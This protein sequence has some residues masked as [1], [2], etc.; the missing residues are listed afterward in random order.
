MKR[1]II[2][3]SSF[4]LLL[5]VFYIGILSYYVIKMRKYSFALPPIKTVLVI[6]DSQTQADIN[7]SILVNVKNLSLAHD[8]YF[9]MF[10]R[11]KLYTDTNPQIDHVIIALSPHTLSPIKDDF[12]HNFGYVDET[13]KHYMP[14]FNIPDW[15]ILIKND[16]ADVLSS[17][18]TPINY[19]LHPSQDRIKEM[20]FYESADY[21][22]LEEDIKSGATR[23]VPDSCETNYGNAITVMYLHKI[24]D[25]CKGK[26]IKLIGI[27]T[28]VLHGE[29]YFDMKNYNY[30]ISHDFKDIEVWNYMDMAVPDSC[31]RDV[32]HLNKWGAETFSN[33][34]KERLN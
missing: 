31:R 11:L 25:Y 27:N 32:N 28:P 12:F 14:Y 5:I 22:H 29:K 26:N 34:L 30:L 10:T 33:V 19:Y 7:D 18:V 8:G 23:L 1:F 16:P 15:W 13:V 4:L 21:S 17:L 20:G 3:I 2:G 24:I 9:S 6:G